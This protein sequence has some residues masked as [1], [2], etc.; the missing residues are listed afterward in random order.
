MFVFLR[1]PGIAHIVFSPAPR[2][3]KDTNYPEEYFKLNSLLT[4]KEQS[5]DL[6][7]TVEKLVAKPVKRNYARNIPYWDLLPNKQLG[8]TC[9]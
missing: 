7:I 5:H 2:C 1:Q 4:K 6:E 9:P 3:R 8:R